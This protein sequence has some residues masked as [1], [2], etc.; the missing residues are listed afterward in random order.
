MILWEGR[1]QIDGAGDKKKQGFLCVLNSSALNFLDSI[2]EANSSHVQRMP[3]YMEAKSNGDYKIQWCT[4][5]Y[6]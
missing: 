4:I 1:Y 6:P 5:S 3:G 2:V